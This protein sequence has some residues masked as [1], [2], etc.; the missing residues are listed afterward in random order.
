MGRCVFN[1]LICCYSSCD[2]I[3]CPPETIVCDGMGR[4]VCCEGECCAMKGKEPF[5]VGMVKVTTKIE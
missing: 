5:A 3:T 1:G 4:F 2:P